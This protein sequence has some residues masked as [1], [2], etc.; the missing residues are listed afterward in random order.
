MDPIT[1]FAVASGASQFASGLAASQQA[2][3][4]ANN[5][6]AQAKLSETQALQRDT[7]L[8]DEL[9]RFLS[10]TRASRTANGLSALSPNALKLSSEATK[11]S[12]EERQIMTS[13]DRQRAANMRV[14]AKSRRS[15]S[16]LSL[17]TGAISGSIP[18][19][20]SRL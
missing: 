14:A 1:L 17:L 16:R 9:T 2:K 6:D 4:E 20:E 11:V 5:L 13:N 15:G 19:I 10:S 8:R 7:S 18:L 3:S 12:S